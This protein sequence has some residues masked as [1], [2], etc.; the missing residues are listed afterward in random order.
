MQS[1]SELLTAA[2]VA[3]RLNVRPSTITEWRR[4]GRIPSIRISHKVIRFSMA[5]VLDALNRRP[6]LRLHGTE[7]G[8]S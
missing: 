6:A 3:A 2:D 8:G 7:G 4:S 1:L 5:E